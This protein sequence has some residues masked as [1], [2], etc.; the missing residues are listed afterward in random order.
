MK[1]SNNTIL[2][3]GGATGI[4]LALARALYD[5]N[6]RIIVCGRNKARLDELKK[7]LPDVVIYQCNLADETDLFRFADAVLADYPS[8]NMLI[9]NAGVQYNY[10]FTEE[11]THT[12]PI[13]EEVRVNLLAPLQLSE[14]LLPH[15]MRQEN[16]AIVNITSALAFAPKK[17]A[18]VYCATKAAMRSF[19]QA[20]RYQLEGSSVAVFELVPSLV[21]TDMTQGRGNG[22]ISPQALAS[23]ALKAMAADKHDI[24]IEKTKALYLLYRLFP[25]AAY[26]LLKNL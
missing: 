18:A 1:L 4:G 5:K 20:L 26:R 13:R 12:V 24:L 7:Q 17:C 9:N 8:I 22:K 23:E 15:L 6:N 14:R 21:D 16:A 2:I 19:T 10:L 3:T 11:Q 25:F